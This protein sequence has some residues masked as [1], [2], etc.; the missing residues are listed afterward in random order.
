MG[1]AYQILVIDDESSV[2]DA[3]RMILEDE[4]YSVA[5]AAT[6]SDGIELARRTSFNLIIT[7][8]RLPDMTGL[9][10]LRAALA[11]DS[12]R[13][14]ILITAQATP[15]ILDEARSLGASAALSKPFLPSD[16]LRLVIDILTDETT[17]TH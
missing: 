15:E 9:D 14:V 11:A 7:D 3:L 2:A 4:G 17:S 1:E 12:R 13:P 6:G 10:V 5:L 16:I 8:L